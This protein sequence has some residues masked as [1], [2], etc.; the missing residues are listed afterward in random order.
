MPTQPYIHPSA[1][2][3][4]GAI[5]GDSV[6][7]W[8]F[9][10]IMPQARLGT[11]TSLGQN[12]FVAS[13]VVTGTNCKVQNNVSLYQGVTLGDNVFLGPSCVFTNV[14]NPRS[15]VERRDAYAP[16]HLGDGASVGANATILCGINVGRYA[17][18]GAGAVVLNNVPD[19]AIMVGNPAVQN[20]W[21]S[22]HGCRLDFVD[23]K[24]TCS[25]SGE[26]YELVVDSEG[27]EKVKRV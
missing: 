12:C 22:A 5:L 14:I 18:V 7:V 3:D 15:E 10:H 21:M 19:F 11:G 23:F 20:G 24:G 1:V 2:V 4:E 9:C 13:G 8:H 27:V 17:F 25:E 6:K 26:E 16:T